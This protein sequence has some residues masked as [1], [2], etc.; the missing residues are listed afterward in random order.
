MR[1]YIKLIVLSY[2]IIFT[3]LN[4]N[5]AY[6]ERVLNQI[7]KLGRDLQVKIMVDVNRKHITENVKGEMITTDS[8]DSSDINRGLNK[9][10]EALNAIVNNTNEIR[11]TDYKISE[12]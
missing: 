1:F 6:G 7:H 9:I 5:C 2:I 10:I 12:Q 3:S 11:E 4:Q 8:G